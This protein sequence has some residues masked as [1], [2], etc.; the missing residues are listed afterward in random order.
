MTYDSVIIRDSF[1]ILNKSLAVLGKELD[2][3]VHKG[4]FPQDF[5]NVNTLFYKG[6][7]PDYKYYDFIGTNM[8]KKLFIDTLYKND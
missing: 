3:E 2:I 1:A 7:C 8:D 4:Y 6:P 5:A